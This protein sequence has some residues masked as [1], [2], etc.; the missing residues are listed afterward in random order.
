MLQ[1]LSISILFY[2]LPGVSFSIFTTVII[3]LF[4][5]R[6]QYNYQKIKQDYYPE[7]KQHDVE[8][9]AGTL[10]SILFVTSRKKSSFYV[11]LALAPPLGGKR[12]S[13]SLFIYAH[14]PEVSQ[15]I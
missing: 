15:L 6:V 5:S 4:V 8:N 12:V 9:K 11:T 3:S 14:H 1:L 7:D 10:S 13:V 2:R